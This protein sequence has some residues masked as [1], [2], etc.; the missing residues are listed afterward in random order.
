MLLDFYNLEKK[1]ISWVERYQMVVHFSVRKLQNDTLVATNIIEIERLE[2]HTKMLKNAQNSGDVILDKCIS[3][4]RKYKEGINLVL[5]A[6]KSTMIIV[7]LFLVSGIISL[8]QSIWVET[9]VMNFIKRSIH[10]F[11]DD[12][13]LSIL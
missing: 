1:T 6:F 4:Y 9:L 11:T 13:E 12:I 2:I 7:I 10:N 3:E 5:F 8:A